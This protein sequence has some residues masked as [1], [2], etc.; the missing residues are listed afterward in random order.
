MVVGGGGQEQNQEI[1]SLMDS[2]GVS[3][4]WLPSSSSFKSGARED[5]GPADRTDYG[6]GGV[7]GGTGWGSR[8]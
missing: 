7:G 2:S 3:R 1:S 4:G 8:G 6:G 5:D